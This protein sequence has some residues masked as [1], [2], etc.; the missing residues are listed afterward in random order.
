[1]LASRSVRRKIYMVCDKFVCLLC[2]IRN[3]SIFCF[4]FFFVSFSRD[5]FDGSCFVLF[6]LKVGTLPDDF[7]CVLSFVFLPI[8]NFIT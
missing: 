7:N 6:F 3:L 4:V 1:M 8:H 5:N 2:F